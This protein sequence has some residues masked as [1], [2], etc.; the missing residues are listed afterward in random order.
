DDVA[1]QEQAVTVTVQQKAVT[2]EPGEGGNEGNEGKG[3]GGSL[4]WQMLPLLPLVMLRQRL[5]AVITK[6]TLL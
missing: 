4:P 3:G 6:G 5:R 1:S 2:P